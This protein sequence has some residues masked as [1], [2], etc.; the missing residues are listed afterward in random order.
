MCARYYMGEDGELNDL[1][2]AMVRSPLIAVIPPGTPVA[3]GGEVR[4]GTVAPAQAVTRA[5]DPAVF[6][7]RWGF[8]GRSLL[9]NA[10]AETAAVRPT[11]REAW[12]AHRCVLPAAGYYE[13]EHFADERGRV[14]TGTKYFIRPENARVTWLCGLY[15]IEAG[16]PCFRGQELWSGRAVRKTGTLRAAL[17][18]HDAAVFLMK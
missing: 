16:L 18:P 8:T 9:I 2:A 13:W 4:P 7:M 15:R 5:G 12:Q 10:R 6:P 3:R 1:V 11:F 14:H 17:P